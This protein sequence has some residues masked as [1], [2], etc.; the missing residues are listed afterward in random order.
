MSG[1]LVDLE[2]EMTLSWE[3]LAQT[4]QKALSYHNIRRYVR[5]NRG[6]LEPEYLPAS[7]QFGDIPFTVKQETQCKY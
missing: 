5:N 7:I 2:T 6:E 3:Q 4:I 1:R